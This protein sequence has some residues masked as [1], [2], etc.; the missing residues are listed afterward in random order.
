MSSMSW[1]SNGEMKIRNDDNI[2][3]HSSWN[4]LLEL[5]DDDD[6]ELE[7]LLEDELDDDELDELD[8]LEELEEL[9]SDINQKWGW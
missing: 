1:K 3:D 9:Q 6:D 8:E 4:Y 5:L 2:M 7:L